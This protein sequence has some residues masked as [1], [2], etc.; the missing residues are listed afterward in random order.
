MFKGKSII[1]IIPARGGSK[2]LLRK[3]VRPFCGKPLVAWTIAEAKKSRY[4]DD[5]IVSTD[6][7]VISRISR[8]Y[9]TNVPFKRP[10]SLASD[11]AKTVDVMLHALK[12][13]EGKGLD[14]DIVVLLQPTS[15]LRTAAD[16]DEA[17]KLLFKKHASAIVSVC[18][19]EHHPYWS[20]PLQKSGSM[21]DFMKGSSRAKRTQDMPV[22]Y[23][24]NGAVYVIYSKTLK[25]AK[26][27]YGDNTFAYVMP[28]GRSID[29]DNKEDFSMAEYFF[30]ERG[31]R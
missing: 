20:G 29:I 31:K 27:F 28:V 4:L 6:D 26:S 14:Y 3:N 17:V 19:V 25:K 10:A 1:G 23:R 11:K 22:F 9:C 30:K 15:P 7:N 13:F 8:K 21:R 16:I 24:L 18:K 2:R 5:V 12:W